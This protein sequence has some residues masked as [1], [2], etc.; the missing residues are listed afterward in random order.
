[1]QAFTAL[2]ASFTPFTLANFTQSIMVN[3]TN[4]NNTN[5]QPQG[6]PLASACT[7]KPMCTHV[8]PCRLRLKL[9]MG[10]NLAPSL[11]RHCG[12]QSAAESL[13]ISAHGCRHQLRSHR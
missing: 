9:F 4:V 3:L 11:P 2:T 10:A 8:G 5:Q 7:C 12:L 6:E 13:L 1:M